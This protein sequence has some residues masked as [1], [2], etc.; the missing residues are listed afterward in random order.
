M[1]NFIEVR[2]IYKKF[3]DQVV[4]KDVSM[5]VE[6]GSI[7]GLVGLNGSGKTVLMKIICGFIIPDGGEVL[8]EGKRI[9]RD[10][11]FPPD[12]GIIIETPGFIPYISGF[13]N[14]QW[15]ASV[16]HRID[17]DKI[18][19][20]MKLVGLDPDSGKWVSKYSLGMKQRLAIAQAVMEEQSLIVLDEPTN[21]LDKNG[22]REIREIF[23]NL[24]EQGKTLLIASHSQYDIDLLCDK[25]YE[26]DNGVITELEQEKER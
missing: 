15:L 19:K 23:M 14:L 8:V 1:E 20:S 22:V 4:L 12:T 6:R 18:R 10:V 21:G 26:M 3:K 11:D 24:R 17:A 2:N 9:G 16:N 13:S 5:K 25:V 7:C